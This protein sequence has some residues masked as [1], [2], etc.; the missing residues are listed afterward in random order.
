MKKNKIYAKLMIVF[1][2]LSL[3]IN[4]QTW[5]NITYSPDGLSSNKV[6][7]VCSDAA[8][9][10]WIATNDSGFAR[11]KS[12]Q[13]RTWRDK[14]KL[15]FSCTENGIISNTGISRMVSDS[16]NNLYF[17]SGYYNKGL[18][19][20]D[21]IFHLI[22]SPYNFKLFPLAADKMGNIWCRTQNGTFGGN[23]V[24]KYSINGLWQNYTSV[25]SGLYRDIVNDITV[26]AFGNVWFG[27][28]GSGNLSRF[29]G[30]NWKLYLDYDNSTS[31]VYNLKSDNNG[32][33]YGYLASVLI[34]YK[35]NLDTLIR[36]NDNPASGSSPVGVDINNKVWT[37]SGDFANNSIKLF[38]NSSNTNWTTYN[39]TGLNL[40]VN[41]IYFENLNTAWLTGYWGF[42][43]S[44]TF[45]SNKGL[46]RYN[47]STFNLYTKE[48][49]GLLNNQTNEVI[50]GRNLNQ[51]IVSHNDGISILDTLTKTSKVYHQYNT[52]LYNDHLEDIFTDSRGNK[53]IL[54]SSYV[55][56]LAPDNKTWDYYDR[57]SLLYISIKLKN[58]EDKYGNIWFYD[59][60]YGLSKIS[61]SG[62]INNISVDEIFGSGTSYSIR[63]VSIHPNGEIWVVGS[64]SSY[65]IK[66]YNGTSWSIVSYPFTNSDLNGGI[67]VD[68]NSN[69]WLKSSKY[70][71]SGGNYYHSLIR[72][73][74]NLWDTVNTGISIYAAITDLYSDRYGKLWLMLNDSGAACY[75]GQQWIRYHKG[76]SNILSNNIND[77]YVDT[78]GKVWF[79][80][81][82]GISVLTPAPSTAPNVST[83]A[84]TN[85]T[86]YA[87]QVSG[88]ILSNGGSSITAKGVCWA[89]SSNPTIT[90]SKT[91]D[92]TGT[93]V[94]TS[95]LTALLPNTL[96]YVRAYATN[97][98]GTAYGNQVSFTTLSNIILPTLTTAS[99]TNISSSTATSGGNISSDGGGAITSKGVC[100]STS[101]NPTTSNS[102]TTDGSGS[103]SF[104][105][106]LTNL[107]PNTTYYVKAYSINSIGTAYGNE[108]SFTTTSLNPGC[109]NTVL[110][111][112]SV[113][114][115]PQSANQ[116]I[117]ITPGNGELDCNFAGEYSRTD[118]WKDGLKY[119]VFS[120]R[121]TDF[122]TISD[123]NNI[124][125]KSGVQPLEFTNSGTSVKRIHVNLNSSCVY[126]GICRDISIKLNSSTG[127]SN[128]SLINI[129]QLFPNPNNGKMYLKADFNKNDFIEINAMNILGDCIKI[130]YNYV[131]NGILELNI[132]DYITG[133]ITLEI[134]IN[135]KSSF[136]KVTIM[137]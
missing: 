103:G 55:Q 133:I 116:T 135:G 121:N 33:V 74:N 125:I 119:T 5:Q 56:K 98:V 83:A 37:T 8:G 63:S 112:T 109:V 52:G 96:Y 95:N 129:L 64:G 30:S 76:N 49:A 69:V 89:T 11:L 81:N 54:N 28:E 57:D 124:V 16:L 4:A 7:S 36:R 41:S 25:N 62:T 120:T 67:E 118:G 131:E 85:I 15:N 113:V 10:Y 40:F 3:K 87:A 58:R 88:T 43:S 50:K 53:W 65:M 22:K 72:N 134:T 136:E 117:E 35:R 17:N 39:L 102:K 78:L 6:N 101:S 104:I 75:D 122:I 94:F 108:I 71:L 2:V 107:Q 90:N 77:I 46:V 31:S 123:D 66:K 32:D 115:V 45:L 106:T 20:F 34:Q 137:K 68:K 13:F 70:Y 29:N 60:Y 130:K 84:A 111:P 61:L 18:V 24:V 114:T 42:N 51:L 86:T 12:G 105:S 82:L 9:N 79:S 27:Y 14:D 80:T 99:I 127:L 44:S 26:D 48:N 73:K 100:W 21:S 126:E 47:G 91:N 23:G 1:L 92:G 38:K 59:S 110:W 128:Y 132:P 93:G 97:S 19:K